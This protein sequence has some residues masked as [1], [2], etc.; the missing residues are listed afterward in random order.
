MP[1]LTKLHVFNHYRLGNLVIDLATDQSEAPFRHL[2]LTGPNAAGK[3]TILARLTETIRMNLRGRNSAGHED[4]FH[5]VADWSSPIADFV[6]K[7]QAGE[8][9]CAF[10]PA[11]RRFSP[12]V[13]TGPSRLS[14]GYLEPQ[15]QVANHIKQYLV[16]LHSQAR[17]A[18]EDAPEASAAI[19]AWLKT[20]ERRLAE[21]YGLD[22]L[23]I[24]FDWKDFDVRFREPDGTTYPFEHL[25]DGHASVLQ[26][27][28]ELVLRTS[29][30]GAPA[31][32]MAKP[33]GVVLIDELDTHLHPSLQERILPFLVGLFPR[34]QFIVATHS[35]A[36]ISS[37]DNAVVFDLGTKERILSEELRGTP[38]GRLMTT[39]F[40]L[41][42]DF[43]IASTEALRRLDELRRK[44]TLTDGERQEL[45]ALAEALR[46]SSHSLALEV[47]NRLEGER[48]ERG[49]S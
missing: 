41:E 21:L 19:F 29:A 33:E 12:N 36:I 4:G 2:V 43:D 9:I 15:K 31:P 48:V 30:S 18:K 23:R 28:G 39:H 20:L 37:A 8:I 7:S 38:Y 40:G 27:L 13:V 3:S 17:M 42:T 14:F 49:E 35:P 32:D 16:N 45:R 6:P 25:A 46:K 34:V 26:I 44:Q 24:E 11:Q 1:Y 22:E 5:V 10:L 47:W